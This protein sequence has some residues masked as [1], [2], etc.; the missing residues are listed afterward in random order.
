MTI[1]H[2]LNNDVEVLDLGEGSD[3]VASALVD[4]QSAFWAPCNLFVLA[5][6]VQPG[7]HLSFPHYFMHHY[8]YD[9]ERRE[10]IP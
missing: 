4:G 3:T 9:P 10:S 5:R 1:R 6:W 8:S 2:I 7:L